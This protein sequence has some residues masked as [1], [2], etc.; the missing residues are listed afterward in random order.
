MMKKKLGLIDSG[1][2]GIMVL[3]ACENAYPNYDYVFIGDQIHAPYGS[4][5]VAEM[6]T[7]ASMMLRYFQKQE[8]DDVIIACNTICANILP[9]LEAC[10]PTMKLYGIIHATAKELP[11]KGMKRV[12]VLAT[13]KTVE[14]H[15]YQQAIYALLP[16]CIV[17]EVA[18]IKLVPLL[19]NGGSEES[20]AL[21]LQAYLSPYIDKVDAVVLG[22]THYPIVK[23]QIQAMM[24]VPVYDS[25]A[26]VV[27][28]I[29]FEKDNYQGSIKVFTTKDAE[30][31]HQQIQKIVKK[32]YH[33]EDLTI[34]E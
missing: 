13:A 16:D 7:Y 26:A 24:Q 17:E 34:S 19:E 27:K 3:N 32:D 33:V 15:A 12:L 20:I 23:A 21:A 14:S 6:F 28:M 10:F 5:S 29:P 18:A 22:C 4:R 2:G 30:V 8:I 11:T 31:L 25:N 1:L 9:K